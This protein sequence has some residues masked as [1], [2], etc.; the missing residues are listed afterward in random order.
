MKKRNSL[1]ELKIDVERFKGIVEASIERIHHVVEASNEMSLRKNQKRKFPR[2]GSPFVKSGAQLKAFTVEDDDME[3]MIDL[4]NEIDVNGDG[5]LSEKESRTILGKYGEDIPCVPE[6]KALLE[7]VEDSGVDFEIFSKLVDE[8]PRVKGQRIQW[9][10]TLGLH[11]Q[12]AQ[13]LRKGTLFD[14]LKALR[15]M[16]DDDLDLHVMDVSEKFSQILPV[17]LT[18]GLKKL[19]ATTWSSAEDFKNT[20][21][22]MDGAFVGNFAELK[23]FY[24]GPEK[25]LGVPNPNVEEGMRREHIERKNSKTW[26]ESHNYK[27]KTYPAIEWEIVVS[28]QVGVDYPHTPREKSK[29]KSQE[30]LGDCGREITPLETFTSSSIAQQAD[31]KVGEI[32]A[33]RLYTGPMYTLYNAVLRKHPLDIL[34]SLQGNS[35][36]TCLFCIVS[37]VTKLSKHSK[38]P[39]SRLL[40]RGLGG[41]ILPP[42]FWGGRDGFRGAVEWGLMSTTASRAVAEQYSGADQQRGTIFEIAA[43]RIDVGADLTWISQYPGEQEF[44][45]PPLTCLEV[46]G[47]PWVDDGIVIFPLRANLNLKGLTFEELVE[48]RKRLHLFMSRNLHEEMDLE[49]TSLI[50]DIKVDSYHLCSTLVD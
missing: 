37:G 50:R 21:F 49:V 40:Y 26:F 39:R 18:E 41:A 14:G 4:F 25:I 33:L 43:G 34:Q 17:I 8:L 13:F 32:I 22:S 46:M 24:E 42:S 6:L 35:Y 19:R 3:V 16:S 15:E 28:P 11:A 10:S 12:L 20:K 36:E 9:A 44:L 38:I 45:F 30:W 47:E 2:Q 29:W 48:R 5:L 31:L 23:D 27:V 7:Q 1:Q